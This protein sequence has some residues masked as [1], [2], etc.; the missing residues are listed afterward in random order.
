S[1]L[2]FRNEKVRR[3]SARPSPVAVAVSPIATR[4]ADLAS[5]RSAPQHHGG[6][7]PLD[8]SFFVRS[9]R[10]TCL[11]TLAACL[12]AGTTEP[13][14]SGGGTPIL[15]VGNSLTYVNDVPGIVQALALARGDSLAVETVALPDYALIDHWND[16]TARGTARGEI[17]A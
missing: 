9:A 17:A 11:V 1:D 12:S 6:T 2:L 16:G 3:P 8:S 10:W 7:M 4:P 14:L 15:F 13:E 5:P